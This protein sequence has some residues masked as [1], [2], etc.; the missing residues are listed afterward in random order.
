MVC[1]SVSRTGEKKERDGPMTYQAVDVLH[2]RARD[3]GRRGQ[4]WSILTRRSR[5]LLTLDEIEA[6]RGLDEHRHVGVR[7]VPIDQIRGSGGRSSDFDCDFNPLQDHSKRRWMSVATARLR[8]K[9]LPPVDLVQVGDVY[10]VVDGHHRISVARAL[11]EHQVEAKLTVC[12]VTTPMSWDT[13]AVAYNR[14]SNMKVSNYSTILQERFL[15]GLRDRLIVL[16]MKL[17]LRLAS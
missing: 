13:R 6:T 3:R 17:R 4:L 5:Y 8:G 9:A 7:R 15:L 14:L 1:Y 10:F 12:Q 11:G 2:S 16:G